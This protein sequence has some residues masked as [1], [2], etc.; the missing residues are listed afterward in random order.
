L[1]VGHVRFVSFFYDFNVFHSGC[2]KVAVKQILALGFLCYLEQTDLDTEEAH[3][4][5]SPVDNAGEQ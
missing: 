3:R 1:G 5:A 2:C 4:R